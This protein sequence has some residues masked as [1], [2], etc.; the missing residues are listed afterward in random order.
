MNTPVSDPCQA[1]D[2]CSP[3]Y[4][5]KILRELKEQDRKKERSDILKAYLL[6]HEPGQIVEKFTNCPE[7][8]YKLLK[9]CNEEISKQLLEG[10]SRS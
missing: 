8:K 6:M 5:C 2:K 1:F 4:I 9:A 7:A 10:N 3:E